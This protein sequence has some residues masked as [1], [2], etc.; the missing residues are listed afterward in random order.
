MYSFE[1]SPL[2]HL[3]NGRICNRSP[4]PVRRRLTAV[5]GLSAMIY[6]T[7]PLVEINYLNY[8]IIY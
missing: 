3:R 5:Y 6:Y 1:A 2:L 4:G 8:F 7:P